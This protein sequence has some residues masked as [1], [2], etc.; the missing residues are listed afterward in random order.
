MTRTEVK[1]KPKHNL[2]VRALLGEMALFKWIWVKTQKLC[3]PE[4]ENYSDRPGASEGYELLPKT[5]LIRSGVG[6]LICIALNVL[7]YL[8][9]A[10]KITTLGQNLYVLASYWMIVLCIVAVSVA[11][12]IITKPA[13]KRITLRSLTVPITRVLILVPTAGIWMFIIWLSSR[14]GANTVWGLDN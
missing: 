3:K 2:Y 7:G 8:A 10:Q 1:P 11:L 9:P 6:Y 5:Y 4:R 13:A 14:R 12:F